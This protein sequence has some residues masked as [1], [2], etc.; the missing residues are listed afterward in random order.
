MKPTLKVPEIKLLK[1][2]TQKLLL[3]FCFQIQLALLHHGPGAA[4]DQHG[5][6]RRGAHGRAAQ[7]DPVKPELKAR[8][9]STL[10]TK[11]W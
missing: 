1:L 10:K 9:V 5:P 2:K 4:D 11:M 3:M 7:V 8:M 6:P